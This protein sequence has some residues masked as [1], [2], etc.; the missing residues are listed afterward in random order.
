MRDFLDQMQDLGEIKPQLHVKQ[1]ADMLKS[2]S[3]FESGGNYSQEEVD[4]YRE[5]MNEIDKLFTDMMT[6]RSESKGELTTQIEAL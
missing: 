2:C 6:K 5:Q 4:W 3:L 1:N